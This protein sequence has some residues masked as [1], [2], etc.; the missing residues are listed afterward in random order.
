M[1]E[2]TAEN[3][4]IEGW[5]FLTRDGVGAH[6]FREGKSFCGRALP[7]GVEVRGDVFGAGSDPEECRRCAKRAHD[8]A[9]A[10]DAAEN[11]LMDA[12]DDDARC[13]HEWE[14]RSEHD[15]WV[16]AWCQA[17]TTAPSIPPGQGAGA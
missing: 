13:Q 7:A 5:A 9:D 4:P 1:A 16:C 8:E 12:E 17:E 14:L 3:G 15:L 11:A 6:Y 10:L 2:P